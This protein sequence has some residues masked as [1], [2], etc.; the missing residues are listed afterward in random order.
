MTVVMRDWTK[1][2]RH[3]RWTGVNVFKHELIEERQKSQDLLRNIQFYRE[4][5]T[6]EARLRVTWEGL[7]VK[8]I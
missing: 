1:C 4:P 7:D 6:A 2:K 8:S 5:R 3:G